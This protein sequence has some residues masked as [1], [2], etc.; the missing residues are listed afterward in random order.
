MRYLIGIDV[1]TT[2]AKALLIDEKGKIIAK[3]SQE[4]PLLTPKIG[5][6]EQNPEDWWRKQREERLVRF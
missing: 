3:D 4:Y 5:W 2:G 6:A 1:G